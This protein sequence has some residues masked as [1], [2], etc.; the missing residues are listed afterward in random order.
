ML[1]ADLQQNRQEHEEIPSAS[2]RPTP[3][4]PAITALSCTA[5]S[6]LCSSP[7]SSPPTE[8]PRPRKLWVFG[9]HRTLKHHWKKLEMWRTAL[10]INLS[11]QDLQLEMQRVR[12]REEPSLLTSLLADISQ[13]FYVSSSEEFN[14]AFLLGMKVGLVHGKKS[15]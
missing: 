8:E 11:G 10:I 6:G 2:A 3:G 15:A 14:S 7:V 5:S 9:G 13:P 4:T 1:T 12:R